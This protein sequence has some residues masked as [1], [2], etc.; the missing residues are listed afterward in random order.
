MTKRNNHDRHEADEAPPETF[1]VPTDATS[2]IEPSAP[3]VVAE[4]PA[5][6]TVAT[7]AKA[8]LLDRITDGLKRGAGVSDDGWL[9]LSPGQFATEAGLPVEPFV[10]ALDSLI[11]DGTVLLAFQP[12][13]AR[14]LV[15]SLR[16]KLAE[17]A[18]P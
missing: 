1:D 14:G 9:S 13:R 8:A 3:A 7:F 17:P 5:A 11:A 6:L 18:A 2:A 16:V 10:A 15:G 4:K 12:I